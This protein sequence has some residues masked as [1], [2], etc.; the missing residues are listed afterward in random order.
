M[1][2]LH[3]QNIVICFC[4]ALKTVSWAQQEGMGPLRPDRFTVIYVRSLALFVAYVAHGH[5]EC[6]KLIHL[7]HLCITELFFRLEY[8]MPVQV[9]IPYCLISLEPSSLL[10]CANVFYLSGIICI[11][12][13]IKG[14]DF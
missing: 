8:E 6:A 5:P 2:V 14:Y 1:P 9:N 4:A 7:L 11:P 12:K 3:K 10:S 13:S